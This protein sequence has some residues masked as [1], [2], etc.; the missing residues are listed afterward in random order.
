ME[1]ENGMIAIKS[2][3]NI[4]KSCSVCGLKS[5]SYCYH[6]KPP[7]DLNGINVL[8][9][10][11][12][13]CPLVEIVTCKDCKQWKDS[14]GVYRR[15]LGAESKCPINT[16]EVFEGKFYCANGERRE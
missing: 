11:A 1:R 5:G 10:R 15:G 14:D 3:K 4:P 13:D 8:K 16:K 9:E 6:K 7:Y 2:M 12:S